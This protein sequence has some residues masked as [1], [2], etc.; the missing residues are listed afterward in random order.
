MPDNSLDYKAWSNAVFSHLHRRELLIVLNL[1]TDEASRQNDTT[2]AERVA[3]MTETYHWMLR[4]FVQGATDPDRMKIYADIM[5]EAYTMTDILAESRASTESHD[6]VYTQ[7]AIL[8]SAAGGID[9][10]AILEESLEQTALQ[11]RLLLF[12]IYLWLDTPL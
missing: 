3:H 5:A 4:Y 11:N 1:L 8:T 6:Y 9:R 7:K 12:S 2:S 10:L